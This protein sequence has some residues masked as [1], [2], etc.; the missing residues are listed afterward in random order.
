MTLNFLTAVIV[1]AS[2]LIGGSVSG[3]AQDAADTGKAPAKPSLGVG[4]IRPATP[5]KS[6]SKN[7]AGVANT[8]GK[9]SSGELVAKGFTINPNS[10][11]DFDSLQDLT[12]ADKI[13]IT[14]LAVNFDLSYTEI[15][16][17]FAVPNSPYFSP[18]GDVLSGADFIFTDSG[19]GAVAVGGS[20]L[21]I[22][23]CNNSRNAIRYDQL[24]AYATGA[25]LGGN[26]I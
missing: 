11:S 19:G 24:T 20:D 9:F 3:L 1:I 7:Q 13:V 22:R 21:R 8:A 14:I 2:A 18:A 26:H 6:H 5:A 16:P 10:C 15:L 17:L 12:G 23:V 25:Q 4:P